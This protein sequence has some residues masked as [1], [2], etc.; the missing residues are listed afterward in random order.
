MSNDRLPLLAQAALC[1]FLPAVFAGLYVLASTV[2]IAFDV[3]PGNRWLLLMPA[4][5]IGAGSLFQY[6]YVQRSIASNTIDQT[7]SP[8]AVTLCTVIGAVLGVVVMPYIAG[9]DAGVRT[10]WNRNSVSFPG[11]VMLGIVWLSAWAGLTVRSGAT[12]GQRSTE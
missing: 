8:M 1:M 9:G 5:L 4:V 11:A 10:P 6:R 12:G 3:E 7:A 2:A